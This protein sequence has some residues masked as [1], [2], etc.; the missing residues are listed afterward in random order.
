MRGRL[1]LTNSPHTNTRVVRG[2]AGGF[3]AAAFAVGVEAEAIP[4]MGD[5]AEQAAGASPCA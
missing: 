4:V 5:E 1:G 3:G 2:D